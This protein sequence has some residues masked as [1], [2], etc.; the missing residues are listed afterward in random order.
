MRQFYFYISKKYK[1]ILLFLIYSSIEYYFQSK[2]SAN[3]RIDFHLLIIYYIGSTDQ[4][5]NT[6]V[7]RY[8]FTIKFSFYQLISSKVQKTFTITKTYRYS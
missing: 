2:E 8:E 4:A 3:I 6:I 5:K 7:F 1:I